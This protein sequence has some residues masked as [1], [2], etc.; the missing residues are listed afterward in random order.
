MELRLKWK[1]LLSWKM[2]NM[3]LFLSL[4]LISQIVW[5]TEVTK[6]RFNGNYLS[7]QIRELW[8]I[9]SVTF[10]L[11]HPSLNQMIRWEICDCYCD[12]IR[13]SLAPEVLQKMKK[14]ETKSLSL[15]LIE[16][17]NSKLL[18]KKTEIRT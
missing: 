14:E 6:P 16:T 18:P 2:K 9:C 5:A 1:L 4:I 11:N 7:G 10:Q 17:C 15:K 12:T 8:Q 13:E 3:I